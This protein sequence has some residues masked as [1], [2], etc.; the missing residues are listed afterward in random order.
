MGSKTKSGAIHIVKTLQEAG[1][2]AY[3]AG[4]WVRDY[5]L[6]H[7][8]DD[9]DIATNAD[10]DRVM[11][12]F[13]HTVPVGEA[14]GV[15]L[16]IEHERSF[17]V[18]SFRRDGRYIGGRKPETVEYS[19]PEEDADRRDFTI[20]GM[21]YDPIHDKIYD[22]V[23][24]QA[25]LK[26]GIIRAIGN[27]NNRFVEDRLRM[28]RGVRMAARFGFQMDYATEEAIKRNAHTLFPAVA[29]ERVWQELIK[30]SK[31]PRFMQAIRELYRLGLLKEIFPQLVN[32]TKEELFGRTEH[33]NSFLAETPTILYIIELFPE[34]SL[35]EHLNICS[36]LRVSN[37]DR[38]WVEFL[39]FAELLHARSNEVEDV[40]WAK[41]YAD[42]RSTVI[43]G[44]LAAR[45][46]IHLRLEFKTDHQERIE[47]L[48]PF[49]ERIQNRDPIVKA[50]DLM[51]LG[52]SPGIQMGKLLKE[53]ER[54]SINK[55]ITVKA[56]IIDLLKESS[57]WAS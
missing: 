56:E 42:T 38:G 41:F 18:A 28:I 1:H 54:I 11:S 52:I 30:M 45:K 29:A 12:I 33:F 8:S 51:K 53:G 20:N 49:V 50:T 13:P 14:F 21:F 5:L 6:G 46:P 16:V 17:E 10:P 9:I 25:D 26:K 37:D 48:W 22:F 57:Y 36:Q 23:G 55:N 44:I 7:P 4:G 47:R 39:D 2:I 19:T 35:V 31:Y 40:E 34:D 24:G 32:L 15:V 3:F 27:A 43:I